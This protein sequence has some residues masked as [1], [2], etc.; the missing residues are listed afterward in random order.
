MTAIQLH[1][2]GTGSAEYALSV[3]EHEQVLQVLTDC[4][5]ARTVESFR[6]TA[7][8]SLSR[9][10]GYRTAT[11]FTGTTF[12]TVF[13]DPR[14]L[15][16]GRAVGMFGSYRDY[17]FK[18]DFFATPQSLRSF[19]DTRVATLSELRSSISTGAR[20]FVAD[21]FSRDGLTSAVG[22]Y[23]EV[24]ESQHALVG[25]FGNDDP[26]KERR[27]AHLLRRLAPPLNAISR[28][29]SATPTQ[30]NLDVLGSLT[31]R[32]RQ[33]ALLIA[34]GLS[35]SA[36]AD[37]LILREDTVKKYVS[38]ILAAL[39]CHSRTQVALLVKQG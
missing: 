28:S 12:S 10:L 22:L 21:Y 32:Q 5:S 7:L 31:E 9:H 17:W 16:T 2:R 33:V 19:Q 15:H 20:Q 35:N 25:L 23:L 34:E 36:I 29:L 24:S 3:G 27:V 13:T 4:S 8:E 38:A 18:D 30:C 26:R 14:P 39:R 37:L 11:V 1:P 6:E